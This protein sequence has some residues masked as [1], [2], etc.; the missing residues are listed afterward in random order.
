MRWNLHPSPEPAGNKL[1]LSFRGKL[2]PRHERKSFADLENSGASLLPEERFVMKV[3]TANKD[4]NV[5]DIMAL[6]TPQEQP[7]IKSKVSDK[8][9]LEKNTALFRNIQSS[10]FLGLQ[11]YGRYTLVYVEHDLRG[12]GPYVKLYPLLVSG[13]R[14]YLTNQLRG[15]F[16]YEKMTGAI[17]EY[18]KD[19]TP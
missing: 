9:L 11:R 4:A 7:D 14:V 2:Y 1:T 13:S 3:V 19:Q 17:G 15:D 10:K 6:W 8:T 16:F 18:L 12:V 5:S